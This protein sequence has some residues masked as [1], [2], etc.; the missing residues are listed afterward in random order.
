M[1]KLW[2][3]FWRGAFGEEENWRGE[4]TL[5]AVECSCDGVLFDLA[6]HFI[7]ESFKPPNIMEREGKV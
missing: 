6:A 4:S 1:V 7:S 5:E 2:G 3:F